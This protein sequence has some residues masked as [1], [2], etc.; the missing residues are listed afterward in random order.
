MVYS[1]NMYQKIGLFA[2]C[3]CW[4]PVIN[5]VAILLALVTIVH[6]LRQTADDGNYD[7]EQRAK[8]LN[9]ATIVIATAISVNIL[10]VYVTII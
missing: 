7:I 2:F 3:I 4:I 9:A 8:A 1:I 6:I 5:I 10:F